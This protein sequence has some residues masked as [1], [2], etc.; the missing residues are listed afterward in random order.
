MLQQE[1]H[2]VFVT[3]RVACEH[4]LTAA[5][6]P[7]GMDSYDVMLECR[8]DPDCPEEIKKRAKKL[9]KNKDYKNRRT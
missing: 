3:E 1:E 8:H 4:R 6:I 7:P 2:I 9:R 5:H